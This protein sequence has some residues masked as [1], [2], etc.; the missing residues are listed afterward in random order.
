MKKCPYCAEEIQDE[1]IICRFCGRDVKPAEHDDRQV[2][3]QSSVGDQVTT[4]E[5][6][7]TRP[8]WGQIGVAV[9]FAGAAPM[10][11][12]ALLKASLELSGLVM[13][14]PIEVLLFVNYIYLA[15]IFLFRLLSLPFGFWVGLVW[16]GKNLKGR[17]LLGLTAGLVGLFVDWVLMK[18]FVFMSAPLD[19]LDYLLALT[20]TILFISG[21]LFADLWKKRKRGEVSE[22][23][24]KIAA[25]LSSAG[26]EPSK[27]MLLIV[28]SLGPSFI[29]LI[30]VAINAAITILA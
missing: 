26:Q 1:A 12:N 6:N 25:Q 7:T 14:L 27:T 29:G 24:E 18:S 2:E 10:V 15:I 17:A 3:D 22:K 30:G 8:E 4:A 20:T 23:E 13:Y 19:I 16:P 11:L 28:Q 9:L 5:P 21:V